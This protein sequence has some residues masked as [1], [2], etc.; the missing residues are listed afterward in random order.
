MSF[1]TG[2]DGL[3][4]RH[5][6]ETNLRRLAEN[7]AAKKADIDRVVKGRSAELEEISTSVFMAS[8]KLRSILETQVSERG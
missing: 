5:I 3:H 1:L 6:L 4:D 2:F 8:Q 7:L